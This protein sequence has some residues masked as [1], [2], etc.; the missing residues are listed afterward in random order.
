V[1]P[2]IRLPVRELAAF[3]H[4]SGDI[5]YRF[6]PSPSAE[7]GIAGHQLVQGRRGASYQA[8]Y[9]LETRVSYPDFELRLAG[10]ADGYDAGA[11]LLE[12]I[13]TCRV[14]RS[15]IPPAV[16]A[17]HW[18]QLAL[19]GGL[20]CRSEP[21][22]REVTLQL[23]YYHVDS[24]EE[25]QRTEAVTRDWLQAFLEDSLA[26]MAAWLQQEHAWRQRRDASL[27]KLDFPYGEFRSGQRTMAETVYK[28]IAQSGQALLE[29]P[30]G[31]GKTAAVLYPALKALVTGR[32]ER[33]AF[34]TARTVGRRAAEHTLRDF[35]TRG[36][37]L[38]RL[39]LSA[40]D[41][42]CFSPGKACHAEDCP[43]AAG[44]YD[45]LP[46]AMAAAVEVA[47]LDRAAIEG[48]AREHEVCPYQLAMDLIP[49]VDLCVA[50]MHY[51]YSFQAGLAATYAQQGLRWSLLLDEAHNL[52]ER[53][54]DMYSASL[55][56][57]ELIAARREAAGAVRKALDACNRA[58]LSLD[59][60]DWLEADYDCREQPPEALLGALQRFVGAVGE[61]L[62]AQ[63]LFLQSRPR[64]LDFYFACLQ[65]QR[66][67]EVFDKDFRF[68]MTRSDAAQGL[69][70]K[71]RCLDAA[72][73]LDVRQRQPEAVA[74]FSATLSPPRWM[75]EEMGLGE[76]AV[77]QSLPSPF[78]AGQFRVV[79]NTG[80][81]TRYRAREATLPAV[82]EAIAGWLADNPGNCIVYFS[83]YR[84]MEEVVAQLPP[85]GRQLL[86][87]ERRWRDEERN[88]L[89]DTLRGER[90]VA[91][92]CI[93]GGVFGEGI[94]LPGDALASVV[95]VGTGLPQFNREREVLRGYYDDKYRELRGQ[96]F[97][98]AYLYPGMQRVSQALGRVIRTETDRGSALLIDPRYGDP[99][100]RQLLPEQW[101]YCEDR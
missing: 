77:Y 66:V 21:E 23:T 17:L 41:S 67:L 89:L 96:G 20:L 52:P 91:A 7:Q 36:M 97:R 80:L 74:A 84:Y 48:I 22:R 46:K 61:Q 26:R 28:C 85:T 64:L 12:E 32:H 51:V 35:E 87:Q 1:K 44:Y 40:R 76:A 95:I 55:D 71:L 53:A 39:S 94:D 47:D 93:L 31:T 63:P 99:E 75:L 81:D 82:A 57:G 30:T 24:G 59:K 86:V 4:R 6:T 11:G 13:K 54:R 65:F 18:A 19:Y 33:V 78:A 101:E 29:A 72:R 45:R 5:D 8:E 15:A 37:A 14:D 83:A 27:S 43:Y 70:V 79:L 42:I 3:C 38:R 92:F 56:K 25:W 50:D 90:N 10:R 98:Y 16:E 73:L 2:E 62:A 100:Y 60:E 69:V 58:L 88:A 49:W 68:E 9:G 34:V